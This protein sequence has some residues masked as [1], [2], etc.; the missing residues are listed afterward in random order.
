VE[1]S[2]TGGIYLAGDWLSH[3]PGWFDGALVSAEAAVAGIA[4]RVRAQ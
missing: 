3:M 2:P 4:A 1:A